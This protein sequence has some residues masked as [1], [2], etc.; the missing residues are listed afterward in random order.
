MARC[1]IV[2]LRHKQV[3]NVKDGTCLGCVDDME[4]D[5]ATAKLVSIIIYGRLKWF[6]LLGRCDDICIKWGGYPGHWGKTRFWYATSNSS[7]SRKNAAFSNRN[8]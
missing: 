8:T 3:V 2:D 4:I 1:R 6:G 7:S 5:M